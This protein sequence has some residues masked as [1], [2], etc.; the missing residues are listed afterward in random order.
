MLNCDCLEVFVSAFMHYGKD[1]AVK[2]LKSAYVKGLKIFFDFQKYSGV[3]DMVLQLGL[4]TFCTVYH[5]AQWSF[6][7]C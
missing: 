2:K 5:N 3:I 6:Y 7:K 1:T 4:P